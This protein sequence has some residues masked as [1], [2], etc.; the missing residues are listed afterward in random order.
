MMAAASLATV[1]QPTSNYPLRAD[2]QRL[3]QAG[4]SLSQERG[5]RGGAGRALSRGRGRGGDGKRH[6]AGLLL[7]P[8]DPACQ[9]IGT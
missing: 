8:L 5:G 2:T 6:G 9:D 1:I 3:H 4:V 7:C